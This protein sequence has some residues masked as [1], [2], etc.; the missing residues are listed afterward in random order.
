MKRP[1]S[2]SGRRVR[3]S[4][5]ERRVIRIHTEGRVTEPDYL[6]HWERLNDSVRIDWG[7]SGMVPM[8]LVQH[9]R[10]DARSSRHASRRHGSPD[11]DEIWCVFDVDAHP[12]VKQA[13]SEAQQSGIRVAVSNPCFELWLVLHCEDQRAHI[14]RRG[15]QRRASE[16]GLI[17]GKSVSE[18]AWSVLD[19]NYENARRRAKDMN[20][21][22]EGNDSPPRSN[23][24]TDIWRLVDRLRS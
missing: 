4:Q 20:R 11:Y 5:E 10:E 22:H 7:E 16:L 3:R 12:N 1:K 23:P 15:I 24:S 21:W 18:D 9:A 6:S 8:S 17:D 19:D 2:T 14:E 13:I